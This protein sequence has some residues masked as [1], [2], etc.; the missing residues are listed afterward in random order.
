MTKEV[1]SFIEGLNEAYVIYDFNYNLIASSV[2]AKK[3]MN[4][5]F[6]EKIESDNK[7][8]VKNNLFII[9]FKININNIGYFCYFIQELKEIKET[10]KDYKET[11]KETKRTFNEIRERILISLYSKKKSINEI[12]INTGVNWKSVEK[13][14]TFLVGKGLVEEVC[15]TEYIRIFDLTK[16]GCEGVKLIEK[17]ELERFVKK[18]DQCLMENYINKEI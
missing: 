10:I 16:I 5:D 2:G 8:Y 1:F 6:L 3:Y 13:H 9:V 18:E 17:R 12:S 7:K 4:V 15:S 11:I 14:L